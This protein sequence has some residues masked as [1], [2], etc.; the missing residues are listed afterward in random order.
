[1]HIIVLANTDQK[2]LL[3]LKKINANVTF[4]FADNYT[5]ILSYKSAEVFFIL[6]N[7]ININDVHG[8]TTLPVFI[9]SVISTLQNLPSNVHRINGWPTFLERTVWEV[10]TKNETMVK[11]IFEKIGWTHIAAPDEPGLIAA[12]VIAMIINEAYFAYQ[13]GISSKEEIDLAMKLGTNYPYGP[14]EWA[15]K[16]GLHNIY[17]LLKTLSNNDNRY[18]PAKALK[19]EVLSDNNK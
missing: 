18:I 6:N 10:A 1:M 13:D 12:R 16:I 7:E 15:K 3:L 5:Q 2:D 17:Y 14:F 19:Q 4:E 9:N 8:I 11:Q